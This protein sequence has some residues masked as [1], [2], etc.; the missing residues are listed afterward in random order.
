L[1][2]A[3]AQGA[4]AQLG[5][6]LDRTQEVGGSSPP[7][8]IDETPARSRFPRKPAIAGAASASRQ[9]PRPQAPGAGGRGPGADNGA[10]PRRRTSL[11]ARWGG[12]TTVAALA[13]SGCAGAPPP[14]GPPREPP[15]NLSCVERNARGDASVAA[16][17]TGLPSSG[18]SAGATRY[19]DVRFR[20]GGSMTL[21]QWADRQAASNAAGR[22]EPN[23]HVSLGLLGTTLEVLSVTV[24]PSELQPFK[25]CGVGK[26]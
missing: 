11:H 10:V 3:C 2:T 15:I 26:P 22:Y 21:I 5:E 20:R 13:I 14:E 18:P 12:L 1:P 7:S 23:K 9:H 25:G 24:D 17:E 4:I 8:S 16:V 19:V 6:R